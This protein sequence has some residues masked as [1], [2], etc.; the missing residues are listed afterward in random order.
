MSAPDPL[1][2]ARH[3][4]IAFI[5]G[6]GVYWRAYVR[7]ARQDPGATGEECLIFT[8]S[9]VVR[10]VWTYPVQWAALTSDEL[11]ALSWQR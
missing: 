8:S 7:D 10:R 11:V 5:D 9:D 1:A 3:E 6:A 4:E 2:S